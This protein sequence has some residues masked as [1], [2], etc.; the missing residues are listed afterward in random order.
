MTGEISLDGKIT[1]IGGLSSKILGSIKSNIREII[2]P[3]EN[4]KDYEDFME[5]Y[6]DKE[7]ITGVKFHPVKT[8][9]DVFELIYEKD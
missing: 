8:I 4:L 5:K 6:K 3:Y 9:H 2:F 1:E 7:E